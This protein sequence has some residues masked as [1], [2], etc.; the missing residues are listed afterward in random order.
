MSA[1]LKTACYGEKI[2][3]VYRGFC[4]VTPVMRPMRACGATD[5]ARP[6]WAWAWP[7]GVHTAAYTRQGRGP[8]A[9]STGHGPV[10][11]NVRRDDNV[12][13]MD[14]VQ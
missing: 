9:T 12:M 2:Q 5:H 6:G 13:L 7:W 10:D 11:N 4:S 1:L 3:T 14:N 8:R